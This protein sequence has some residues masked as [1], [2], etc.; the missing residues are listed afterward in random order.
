[1]LNRRSLDPASSAVGEVF[2]Y[3]FWPGLVVLMT[4]LGGFYALFIGIHYRM[5][6][7]FSGVLLCGFIP[8]FNLFHNS[9]S[10]VLAEIR[11]TI[12]L[13]IIIYLGIYITFRPAGKN[14][15]SNKT[16]KDTGQLR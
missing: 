14:S 16:G 8:A 3:L 5:F 12:L 1:M 10:T 15:L 2:A 4:F 6:K 13:M 9:F 7:N 11:N